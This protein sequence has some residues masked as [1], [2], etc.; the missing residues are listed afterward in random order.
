[1]REGETGEQEEIV[2][3]RRTGKGSEVILH[4]REILLLQCYECYFA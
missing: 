1:V 2:S 3:C 4:Y